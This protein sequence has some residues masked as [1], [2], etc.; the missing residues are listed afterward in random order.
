MKLVSWNV[1]GIRAVMKKDFTKSVKKLKPD[2]LCIQETKPPKIWPEGKKVPK[3]QMTR[4]DVIEALKKDFPAYEQ[5]W[6]YA[7]KPGYSGVLIMS[8]EKVLSC[9]LG[10]GIKK[11]DNEGRVLTVELE[12]FYLVNVYVPNS[13]RDLSRIPYREKEW[14]VDFLKHCKKLEKKKPVIF[15]G[16]FNVAHKEIDLKNPKENENTHGFTKEERKGFDN[17]VKAGFID[18]FRYFYPD[19]TD[20]YTWW[21]QMANCR[22]RNIGWRIDYFC[23]SPKLEKRLKK[24]AIHPDIMGSD[25]CPVSLE[26]S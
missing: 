4:E 15:C 19:K 3:S 16:D 7:E 22:P 1:N 25:H 17:I 23:V 24:A 12:D 10:L 20:C 13:K 2:V 18:T 6:N 26:L 21:S 8:K 9:E 14:D 5:F 11:H